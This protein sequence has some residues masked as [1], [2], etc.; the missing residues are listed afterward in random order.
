MR[1]LRTERKNIGKRPITGTENYIDETV[2][3]IMERCFLGW[4]ES[5]LDGH[6]SEL[7]IRSRINNDLQNSQYNTAA[8][9]LYSVL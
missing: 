3:N 5:V 8:L 6:Y 2:E 4:K 1:Q 9:I 7:K